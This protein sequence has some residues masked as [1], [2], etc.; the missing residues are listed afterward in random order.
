MLAHSPWGGCWPSPFLWENCWLPAA[1]GCA[2]AYL[3]WSS[4]SWSTPLSSG[5]TVRLYGISVTTIVTHSRKLVATTNNKLTA[6][7]NSLPKQLFL[8]ARR[9]KTAF[10]VSQLPSRMSWLVGVVAEFGAWLKI[11]R[12]H[13]ARNRLSTSLPQILD[14]PLEY[15]SKNH[16]G[17]F[18]QQHLS[19]KKVPIDACSKAGNCCHVRLLDF[20]LQKLPP[21][22]IEKDILYV[23][24][25]DK[26]HSDPSAPWYTSVPIGHYTLNKKVSVMCR[27]AGI[28]GHKT[29]QNLRATWTMEL[30]WSDVPEKMI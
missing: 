30:Y 9:P 29:N 28:T 27:N 2:V 16:Q 21:E 13:F 19:C 12:A 20:Y 10:F 18:Q 15:V 3:A 26:T 7:W 8:L 23:W 14:T 5:T 17:T 24:P 22:A 11:L 4:G 6:M 25:L 1:E